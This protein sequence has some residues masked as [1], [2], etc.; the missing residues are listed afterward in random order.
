MNPH[1]G[2]QFVLCPR[3]P[4][5]PSGC[6]LCAPCSPRACLVFAAHVPWCSKAFMRC[7]L[8]HTSRILGLPLHNISILLGSSFIVL[9]VTSTR[10][11]LGGAHARLALAL[12]FTQR[13]PPFIMSHPQEASYLQTGRRAAN[14][15]HGSAATPTPFQM[16]GGR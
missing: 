4:H 2:P 1:A 12:S 14:Q 11:D 9:T 5:D 8:R 7:Y 10:H 13:T 6:C 16:G 15:V 3:R